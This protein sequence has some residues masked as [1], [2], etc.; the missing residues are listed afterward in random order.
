[1]TV[2]PQWLLTELH[3]LDG[4]F[5]DQRY[6]TV[7]GAPD[8]TFKHILK[9]GNQEIPPTVNLYLSNVQQLR[10]QQEEQHLIELMRPTAK[11]VLETDELATIMIRNPLRLKESSDFVQIYVETM[12]YACEPTTLLTLSPFWVVKN[13]HT[14]EWKS[15][16]EALM[17]ILHYRGMRWYTSITDVEWERR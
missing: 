16:V 1:M 13:H 10:I 14:Y 4:I 7:E 17:T 11:L 9:L 5:D 8:S 12:K 2:V 3:L 6:T 15:D